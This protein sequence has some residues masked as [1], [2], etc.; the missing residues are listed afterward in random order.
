M[1]NRLIINNYRKFKSVDVSLNQFNLLVGGNNTGKTSFLEAAYIA[2]NPTPYTLYNIAMNRIYYKKDVLNFDYASEVYNGM[3]YNSANNIKINDINLVGH[4]VKSPGRSVFEGVLN[5]KPFRLNGLHAPDGYTL[6]PLLLNNNF[7]TFDIDFYKVGFD[8]EDFKLIN[9][10]LKCFNN[11]DMILF[12]D[13]YEPVI[14]YNSNYVPLHNYGLGLRRFVYLLLAI[15]HSRNNVLMC[16]EFDLGISPLI[17]KNLYKTLFKLAIKYNVQLLFTEHSSDFI[18]AF[19][20]EEYFDKISI[21]RFRD[22]QIKTFSAEFVER[23]RTNMG[24]DIRI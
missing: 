8:Q 12:S 2:L 3:F 17:A 18:E 24:V 4:I 10:T 23:V 11:V 13:G 7:S 9:D 21:I 5:N 16:D 22:N 15:Y 1:L 14:V 6:T 19:L 20:I